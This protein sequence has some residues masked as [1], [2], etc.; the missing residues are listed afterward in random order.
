MKAALL[1]AAALS[2]PA[3][4]PGARPF[5]PD[6]RAR[7]RAA[8][9]A[10]GESAPRTKHLLPD[11]APR[12]T[13]RLILETSPYL[14][15]HAHNPV[16][17]YA[18]GDAA[19]E[20]PKKLQRPVLVSVGYSTCHW[21][22]VMEDESY[23]DPEV[24]AYLNAHFVAIKV[25][26]EER[27]DVDSIY[28]SALHAMRG[29]GGWPLNVF[30]TP[31]RVPFYGGTYFPR[32][33]FLE[34][35]Q[36]IRRGWEDDRQR[37]QQ[38][39]DSLAAYLKRALPGNS[40]SASLPVEPELL[41]AAIAAYAGAYDVEWGGLRG[42]RKFPAS[43]PVRL[44]LGYHRRTG[45]PNTLR[46][47]V[48]SLE[49]MAAGGLRDQVG[50]GFHRYTVDPYWHVPHFE[51]MLYDNALLT[52]AYLEGWKATGR[53][54]F[55]AIVAE[56]LDYLAREMRSSDG[57][58]HS[59]TDADS[60]RP[61]GETEEG[62]FF[63]WTRDELRSV[64]GERADAVA[65]YYGVGDERSVPWIVGQ[66]RPGGLEEIRAA[67]YAA[68][69]K[70]PHP[71]RDEKV[72]AAWNGLAIS[73]FARAGF[74]FQREDW[75]ERAADAADHL[76]ARRRADGRLR[77]VQSGDGP[78]FLEDHAFVIAGLLDLY[79]ATHEPRWLREALALQAVLDARFADPGGGYFRTASD[80]TALL[81][82]EKSGRDSAI[83]SGNSV[84]ALNLLRLAALT[85]DPAWRE[86]ALHLLSAFHDELGEEPAGH[87]EMLL[88]VDFALEPT[89]EVVLVAGSDL[90][91]MLSPLR[92]AH[93]PNR[94][95]AVVATEDI[96]GLQE[97]IP[98]VAN[99][100]ARQGRTTAYVCENRVCDAPTTDPGVFA[101]Q[102]SNV[103]PLPSPE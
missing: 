67:L 99:K 94:I 56:T 37:V 14:R 36:A 92:R 35:L 102:L 49:R 52:L 48:H 40:A 20:A 69:A 23:D 100:V 43:L 34:I 13:N 85:T 79:E 30:V 89:R 54:S 46:M 45:D 44:L 68:R 88:A 32:E 70:R 11:G 78:A 58:F 63:T 12:Y 2:V 25:D 19:F 24:A 29:S 90:D 65:D 9:E 103:K 55:A 38:T 18:W 84:A 7:L 28:M 72:L 33:R 22:H 74:A 8:L 47:A 97:T 77:R 60:P 98:L 39:A 21:C 87:G 62:W 31:D 86:R 51:K 41:H 91:A 96:A 80:Q 82:R 16:D 75:L 5:D 1:L 59:A 3:A 76:L 66:T 17:W 101:K 42:A 4:L 95:V 81:V 53:D 83:P 93:L 73:A 27:P 6:E 64:L 61:D 26:R 57:G 50:G 15:Q 10:A 71:L